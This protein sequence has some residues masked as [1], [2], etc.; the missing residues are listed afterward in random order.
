MG[1]CGG[2]IRSTGL[3][4]RRITDRRWCGGGVGDVFAKAE[5]MA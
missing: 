4:K 3:V 1:Y 2:G 5:G